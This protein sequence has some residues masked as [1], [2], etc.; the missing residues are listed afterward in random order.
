MR[1]VFDYW[2]F[3]SKYIVEYRSHRIVFFKIRHDATSVLRCVFY[4]TMRPVFYDANTH[5]RIYKP[6]SLGDA[7]GG[8]AH[9]HTQTHTHKHTRTNTH[10]HTHTHT[11]IHTP[12][13]H[14]GNV[15]FYDT[16]TGDIQSTLGHFKDSSECM[17]ESEPNCPIR[18]CWAQC[19]VKGHEALV[20]GVV[21]SADGLIVASCGGED[22]RYPNRHPPVKISDTSV[23]IWDTQTGNQLWT[24]NGHSAGNKD[25]C[26]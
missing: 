13:T 22:R 11:H 17:C 24:L 19:P 3:T 10:T 4:D 6:V 15:A 2:Y 8:S 26:D 25:S 20:K 21:L 7:L 1:P 9:T 14:T 23:M 12:H 16:K 5:A 18:K